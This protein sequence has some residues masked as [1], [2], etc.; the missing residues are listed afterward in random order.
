MMNGQTAKPLTADDLKGLFPFYERGDDP[1]V[2]VIDLIVEI[3][4]RLADGKDIPYMAF[5]TGTGMNYRVEFN[6]YDAERHKPVVSEGLMEVIRRGADRIVV[7]SESWLR[8][9]DGTPNWHG[10]L[11][12]EATASGD[13]CYSAEFVGK[14]RVGEWTSGPAGDSGNLARLFERAVAGE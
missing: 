3:E 7:I 1:P 5:V 13:I 6:N 14:N 10:V 12:V 4:R 9:A 2:Q 11:I 8:N